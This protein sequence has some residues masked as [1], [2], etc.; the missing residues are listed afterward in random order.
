MGLRSSLW[1]AAALAACI[2]M[3]SGA[4]EIVVVE[5]DVLRVGGKLVR[6]WGI[7]APE[8]GQQ[9]LKDGQP[10]YPAPEAAA[11][12]QRLVA[13]MPRLK[14]E[15]REKDRRGRSVAICRHGNTDIGAEMVRKGWAYDFRQYSKGH[16]FDMEAKA[17]GRKRGVW[18]ALCVPPWEWRHPRQRPE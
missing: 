17:R 4:A 1:I 11:A 15:E 16:Y 7:D 13:T 9:C 6:L 14:C 3:P 12:L 2:V 8:P 18:S 5:G 10:W